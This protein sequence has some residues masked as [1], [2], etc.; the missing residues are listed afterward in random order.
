MKVPR[1]GV[2][3][4]PKDLEKKMSSRLDLDLKLV[5]I[6]YVD[7]FYIGI[8]NEM[9]YGDSFESV[10]MDRVLGFCCCGNPEIVLLAMSRVLKKFSNLK[11]D[12]TLEEDLIYLY[13]ADRAELMEHGGSVYGSWVTEKGEAFIRLVDVLV[14]GES[15][16]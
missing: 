8:E 7:G 5:G 12:N 13:V 14:N 11:H 15:N 3:Y 6:K 16:E 1:R 2:K 9:H 4:L 10:L